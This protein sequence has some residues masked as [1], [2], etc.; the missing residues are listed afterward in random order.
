MSRTEPVFLDSNIPMYAAGADHRYRAPCQEVLRRVVAGELD[1]LTSAEVHQEILHRYLALG[2]ATKAREVSE[3]FEVMVPLVLNV[4]LGDV[5][6]ARDLSATYDGLPARDL[7]HVAVMLNSGLV[8]IL[9][10][11]RHFD[12]VSEIERLDPVLL[13]DSAS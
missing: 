3:D 2:L 10:A 11:D 7:L 6:L 9:S 8:K 5:R 4:S 13:A 12:D 1:A